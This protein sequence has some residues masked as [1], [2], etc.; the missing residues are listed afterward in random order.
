MGT[1]YEIGDGT[2]VRW[3]FGRGERLD[4]SHRKVSVLTVGERSLDTQIH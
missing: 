2:A 1:G 3:C 4:N